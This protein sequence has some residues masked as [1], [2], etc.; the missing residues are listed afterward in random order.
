MQTSNG[1]AT[2]RLRLPV[3]FT[4]DDTNV[5]A[6]TPAA[7]L[8]ERIQTTQAKIGIIGLGYVGLPLAVEFARA[9]FDVTGFDVDASK[10]TQI[11]AGTSYIPDVPSLELA[12]VVSAGKLRASADMA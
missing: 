1:S 4:P 9:G 11:N 6:M 3:R 7:Q 5:Q 10:N 12:E 8:L 2:P